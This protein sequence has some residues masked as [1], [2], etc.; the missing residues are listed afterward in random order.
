MTAN[1]AAAPTTST[2][3]SMS[4][5][6]VT[7]LTIIASRNLGRDGDNRSIRARRRAAWARKILTAI[8][9]TPTASAAAKP[10]KARSQTFQSP[11]ES[12]IG[13]PA[14][15]SPWWGTNERPRL[16]SGALNQG[17]SCITWPGLPKE[18]PGGYA[19]AMRTT[20]G[21]SPTFR[22]QESE[23]SGHAAAP[24]TSVMNSRR[25]TRSPRRR[26]RAAWAK[27]RGRAPWRS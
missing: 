4:S 1:T 27:F 11:I 19:G 21:P 22:G 3:K 25:L 7:R 6:K 13:A 2:G 15:S 20:R 5:A 10:R 23:A 17:A 14:Q 16:G 12:V 8:N 18:A 26:G 9:A 24:P